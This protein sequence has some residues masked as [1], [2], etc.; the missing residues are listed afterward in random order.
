M[1]L[2]SV[3]TISGYLSL[4]Q[5]GILSVTDADRRIECLE[6][7]GIFDLIF[8]KFFGFSVGLAMSRMMTVTLYSAVE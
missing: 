7:N 3:D 4:K 5:D 1:L 8:L 2:C 6:I